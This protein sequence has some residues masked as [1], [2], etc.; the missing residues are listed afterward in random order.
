MKQLLILKLTV[1]L[2]QIVLTPDDCAAQRRQAEQ[3]AFDAQRIA[4]AV[5]SQ[6]LNRIDAQTVRM[7]MFRDY[8]CQTLPAIEQQWSECK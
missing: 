6:G 1:L 7:Q 4:A 2:A 8:K 3:A 5:Q